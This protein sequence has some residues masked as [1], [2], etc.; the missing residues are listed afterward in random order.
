MSNGPEY[1]VTVAPVDVTALNETW[2]GNPAFSE[3]GIVST[4]KWSS[5][6]TGVF[7]LIII[8]EVSSRDPN[9]TVKVTFV[10]TINVEDAVKLALLPLVDIEP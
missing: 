1:V 5:V 4:T 2:K 9:F 6:K 3:I 7:G 8:F 10:A